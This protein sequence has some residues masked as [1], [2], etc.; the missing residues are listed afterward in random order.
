LIDELK[1]EIREK[2]KLM[3]SWYVTLIILLIDYLE[4]TEKG[5]KK[6]KQISFR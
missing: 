1:W 5:G 6:M 2:F 4:K 3:G